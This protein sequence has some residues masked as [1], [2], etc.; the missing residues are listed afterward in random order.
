MGPDVGC[1]PLPARVALPVRA[2]VI[3][4]DDQRTAANEMAHG[5]TKAGL[6]CVA[7][8]SP[9]HALRRLAHE[10]VPPVAVLDIRMPELSGLELLERLNAIGIEKRPE[11]ILVSANAN[12]DDARAAMRLGARRLL[13][14]PLDLVELVREV[15]SAALEQE[16]R[17]SR[18]PTTRRPTEQDDPTLSIDAMIALS[19][20]RERFFPRTMLSE[21]CWRMY[22][23]LYKVS[24]QKKAV[25]LTSLALVSG[26]PMATAVRRIHAMRESGLVTYTVDP[27][28]KRRTF[29][30]LSETGARQIEQ[31]L[32]QIKKETSGKT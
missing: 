32:A 28:D 19:R 10:N 26:M 29:V 12:L 14:K 22:L 18:S 25:S 24:L 31:F 1:L 27:K 30:D 17:M 9:W 20:E 23:E 5:L 6:S 13:L 11:V 2:D 4:V 7:F 3:V 8:S 21:H 16:L 15:K